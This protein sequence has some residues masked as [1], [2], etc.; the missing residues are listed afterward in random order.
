MVM[1]ALRR[2]LNPA[3]LM[4]KLV[5]NCQKKKHLNS[6]CK[7]KSKVAG[8]KQD[9]QDTT[10]TIVN[11]LVSFFGI[12]CQL[13]LQ[14]SL[15]WHPDIARRDGTPPS[16]IRLPHSVHSVI[17]GWL[18]SRPSHKVELMVDKSED[19]INKF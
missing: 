2:E 9:Q 6:V 12:L 18:K 16:T 8:G 15:N 10:D 13:Q 1:V 7:S 17:N 5:V 14:I 4:G 3:Q 11:A 19:I